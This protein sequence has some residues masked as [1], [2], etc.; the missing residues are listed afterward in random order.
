MKMLAALTFGLLMSVTA[1]AAEMAK[2]IIQVAE[3]AVRDEAAYKEALPAVIKRITEHGGKY[4]AGG[5]NKATAIMGIPPANRVVLIEY[6]SVDA[7]QKWWKEAG[8][9]DTMMLQQWA[10]F[11]IYNV[12]MVEKKK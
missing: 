7:Y 3:I 11:R 9:A 1:H 5:F 6:D 12:E 4:I 2:P 8:E 10:S